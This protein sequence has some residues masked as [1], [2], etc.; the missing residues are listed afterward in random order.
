MI[1]ILNLGKV[2]KGSW[3]GMIVPFSSNQY[4]YLSSYSGLL[5]I[6]P[7]LD[8]IVQSMQKADLKKMFFGIGCILLIG[9]T[10]VR[11]FSA[12]P[13]A[14]K[15]GYSFLW[16]VILYLVGA[17]TKKTEW[18]Q[19][20]SEKKLLAIGAAGLLFTWAWKLSFYSGSVER[21]QNLWISYLSP[22]VVLAAFVLLII[23][24]RIRRI[25]QPLVKAISFITPMVFGVYLFHVHPLVFLYILADAFT[26]IADLS[27]WK[28]PITVAAAALA[29]F[30]LGV[31]VEKIRLFLFKICK[32][33]RCTAWICG[34]FESW[35]MI[36][37][38]R[39]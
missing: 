19:S 9:G 1:S 37:T 10:S 28:I 5:F 35:F 15:D 39:E 13:L 18:F 30:L 8:Y 17:I 26:W 14:L 7:F 27:P 3:L 20:A 6:M 25:P 22:T 33:D 31:V 29:I 34:K 23:F 11:L 24:S 12:D 2:G 4:W 36:I 16:L 21:G 38:S 32:I